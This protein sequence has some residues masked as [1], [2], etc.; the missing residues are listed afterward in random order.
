[1]PQHLLELGYG[2]LALGRYRGSAHAVSPVVSKLNE[3]P[4][5]TA[6]V[7]EIYRH[8]PVPSNLYSTHCALLRRNNHA[9]KPLN[10]GE[11]CA[12]RR[13]EVP[14][15]GGL[16]FLGD[17]GLGAPGR[18]CR[19]NYC[20]FAV[21]ACDRGK[22]NR[23]PLLPGSCGAARPAELQSPRTS[24]RHSRAGG[25]DSAIRRRPPGRSGDAA[26]SL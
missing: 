23:A 8:G 12:M 14:V 10:G 3:N 6:R 13:L 11:F 15:C 4:T 1:M 22:S 26:P 16:G 9:Y 24:E 18:C 17:Q 25:D 21:T 2:R 5:P 7:G 20:E 19:R